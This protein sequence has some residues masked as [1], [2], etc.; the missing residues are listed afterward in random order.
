MPSVDLVGKHT[1]GAA[2]VLVRVLGACQ[3]A[4]R[5]RRVN[6][7]GWV[8]VLGTEALPFELDTEVF[9]GRVYPDTS[10]VADLLARTNAHDMTRNATTTRQHGTKQN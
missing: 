8:E 7:G 4:L 10:F 3:R 1:V 5:R 2:A 9:V 6:L